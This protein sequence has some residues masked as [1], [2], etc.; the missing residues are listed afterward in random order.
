VTRTLQKAPVARGSTFTI[1]RIEHAGAIAIQ[2]RPMTPEAKRALVREARALTALAGLRAPRLV[3]VGSD[4]EGPFVVETLVEGVPLA[5]IRE[6]WT[7][8]PLGL[9]LHLSIELVRAF[10]E[11]HAARDAMGAIDF[12]HGD[13]SP[14]NVLIT[15]TSR[16]V[17]V[18]FG[19]SISRLAPAE[20]VRQCG[21]PPY[22]APELLRGE[23][24]PSASTDRYAVA[25]MVV[26][27]LGSA[28]LRPEKEEAA[29]LVELA[30]RGIDAAAIESIPTAARRAIRGLLEVEPDARTPSLAPLLEALTGVVERIG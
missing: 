3:S 1:A 18:D 19:E 30:T 25:A 29:R 16:A 8:V 12:A 7:R 20:A 15:P 4:D 22:A 5:S 21:T 9:A 13:P 2:K 27:L 6:A 28:P 11:I 14:E 24:V 26:S 23:A 10:D 17:L